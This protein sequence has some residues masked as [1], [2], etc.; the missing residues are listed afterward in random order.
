MTPAHPDVAAGATQPAGPDPIGH[1]P[2]IGVLAV[3]GGFAEHTE[4]LT[5]LGA[6]VR[7]VRRR[8][9]LEGLDGLVI[10]GGES[11]TISRLLQLSEMLE[12]IS[13]AIAEGLPAFGTCA[14]LIMLATDVRDTRADAKS[15]EA[16]DITVRRNAFGRQVDSF[17]TRVDFAGIDGP[18]DAVFIRAPQV[19]RV[20][21]GVDTVC[22]LDDGTVV[23]IRQGSVLGTSFHPELTADDRVHRYFLQMVAD[24]RSQTTPQR[25][26]DR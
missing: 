25:G 10:P 7:A 4:M 16:V 20:G 26:T 9:H 2:L 5:R 11:T 14:G 24:A 17:E 13:K 8:P 6:E 19:E 3:Q 15:L 22:A 21:E 1:A 18:V 23:G 12:P